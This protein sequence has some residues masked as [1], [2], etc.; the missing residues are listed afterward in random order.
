MGDREGKGI[1]YVGRSRRAIEP[2]PHRH[3]VLDLLLGCPAM[4]GYRL[5]H[6]RWG[7]TLYR[8]TGLSRGQ[9]GH[10]SGVG[11]PEGGAGKPSMAEHLFQRNALWA[12][13]TQE[14]VE[15][16][17]EGSQPHLDRL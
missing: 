12:A 3:Q 14:V 1:G 15:P 2:E 6:C 8:H 17:V 13:F 10:P 16:V 9:T 4:A 11:D 5:L 7:V